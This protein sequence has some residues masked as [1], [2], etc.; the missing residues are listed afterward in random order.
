MFTRF[1]RAWLLSLA[2]LGGGCTSLPPGQDV[3]TSWEKAMVFVPGRTQAADMS[4]L[5]GFASKPLPVVI[6]LHGCSGITS[7]NDIPWAKYISDLGFVV[8]LPDSLARRDRGLSCDPTT[9]QH[10][11]ATVHARRLEEVAFTIDKVRSAA[12]ANGKNIFLMG[13]SEGGI[14]TARTAISGFRGAIIS[15]WTCTAPYPSFDGIFLPLDT[16]ILTMGWDMDP[17]YYGGRY[18]G[19]CQT[20]F[21]NRAKPKHLQFSGREH[22]TSHIP[23]AKEALATFLKENLQ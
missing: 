18:Q 2:V 8:I 13:H 11:S 12:W 7:H 21:A 9:A 14:A 3:M 6:Y 4:F 22:S 15:G 5:N 16:P 17:W 19:S 1:C 23:A 10:F 20:K